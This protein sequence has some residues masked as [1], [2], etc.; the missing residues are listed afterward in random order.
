MSI[1][2]RVKG[3]FHVFRKRDPTDISQGNTMPSASISSYSSGRRRLSYGNERSIIA[4]IY[5]RISVDAA[6]LKMEIVRVD[7]NEKYLETV[8]TSGLNEVLSFQANKDQSGKA[9]RQDI[10]MSLIDEGSIAIVPTDT[11]DEVY[12]KEIFDYGIL[13]MRVGKIVNW[14]PDYVT[15]RLL[16]D[17]VGI[18]K[19]INLRKDQVA[20]V[21]NPFYAIMNEPNS[22]LKRLINKLNMLDVVDEQTSSGKLDIII[23]LPYATKSEARRAQAEQRRTDIEEQ[24]LGSKYGIAYIDGTEHITQL[25]RPAENNLM[26]QIEYL[27]DLLFSQ[28]G[29]TKEILEGTASEEVMNNYYERTIEPIV[30]SVTDELTR[31]FISKTALTQ[32]KRVKA[33]NDPFRFIPTSKLPDIADKFIRNEI[34]TPNE[35]RGIIGYRPSDSAGADELNNPNISQPN[36][37][38]PVN[39]LVPENQNMVQPD[40]DSMSDEEILDYVNSQ[41]GEKIE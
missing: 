37:E 36:Q 18:T 11:E 32:G 9:F 6:Q 8:K 15:I 30:S 2:D 20:I 19:D 5:N 31:K 1:I 40:L 21:E 28:L 14:F 38:T 25:N 23:Q 35:L 29:I 39:A 27:F 17:Q 7:E 34:L 41:E 33:F 13:T 26:N 12:D 24:L 4:A 22:T 16:D 3:A 10:F